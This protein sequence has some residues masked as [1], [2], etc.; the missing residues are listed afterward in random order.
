MVDAD[1]R[2]VV[3]LV[4]DVLQTRDRRL[5]LARQVRV[6]RLADVAAHDLIDR[7]ACRRSPRRAIRRP[8]ANPARRAGQSP[9]ASVVCRPTASRRRQISGTFSTSIQWYWTF[10]RS[11]MSA[12]SR[13]NSVEI[14]PIV[15]SCST[16]ERAA[17]AADPQHEVA[18]LDARRCS[19]HRSR[20]RR[21]PACAGYRAPTSGTGRAGR[22]CRCCRSPAGVDVLDAGAHVER[23]VVLLGLFVGVERLAVAER[24]LAFAAALAAAGV[25]VI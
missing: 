19:R 20:C 13:A 23:V 10:S 2:D 18:V 6:L 22:S 21:S 12:V 14:S 4:A 17:V 15:R 9:H 8:A 1:E 7:R 11:E 3:D 5:V 25:V 24:P 16:V